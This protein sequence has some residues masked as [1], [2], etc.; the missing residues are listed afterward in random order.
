MMRSKGRLVTP[1]K[2]NTIT[3]EEREK[4]ALPRAK[5]KQDEA[6]F[7]RL[8]KSYGELSKTF[9]DRST[10]LNGVIIALVHITCLMLRSG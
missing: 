4:K 1:R 2:Y 10:L 7:A 6:E 3:P 5:V 9:G 8:K